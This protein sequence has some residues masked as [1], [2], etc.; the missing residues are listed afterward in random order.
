M[1]PAG[2]MPQTPLKTLQRSQDLQLD[3]RAIITNYISYHILLS[4]HI[5]SI[6]YHIQGGPKK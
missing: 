6:S 3:L 1:I 4:Y 2:A 5:I